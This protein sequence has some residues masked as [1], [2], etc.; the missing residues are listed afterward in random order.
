[1]LDNGAVMDRL[2]A[3]LTAAQG[4][5]AEELGA[6][7][8]LSAATDQ[9]RI[10]EL[11]NAARDD[12]AKIRWLRL[13]MRRLETDAT[14]LRADKEADKTQIAFLESLERE[15]TGKI[16]S[17]RNQVQRLE[18]AAARHQL[19]RGAQARALARLEATVRRGEARIVAL[20]EEAGSLRAATKPAQA[21]IAM[22]ESVAREDAATIGRL[23][24][25]L[26]EAETGRAEGRAAHAGEKARLEGLARRDLARIV[27]LESRVRELEGQ[28]ARQE[29]E[30][31]SMRAARA[32]AEWRAAVLEEKVRE[33]EAER[34]DEREAERK[35]RE[36]DMLAAEVRAESAILAMLKRAMADEDGAPDEGGR[37]RKRGS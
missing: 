17:L 19:D 9:A 22:L 33:L 11:E 24:D 12:S 13:R 32:G 34:R 1:V 15:A 8:S 27:S 36:H 25:E 2:A 7:S 35:S 5:E 21:R 16:G 30:G 18:D 14:S 29:A 26:Q 3:P 6:D 37:K 10:A 31:T 23:R 20:E 4:I 28:T